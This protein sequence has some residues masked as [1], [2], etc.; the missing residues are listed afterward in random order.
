MGPPFALSG[1]R[2]GFTRDDCLEIVRGAEKKMGALTPIFPAPG[3]GMSLDR[4]PEML[5][6]YGR[7]VILLIGGGPMTPGTDLVENC[8][9]FRALVEV[10]R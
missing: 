2:F 10:A 9:R 5:G 7:E 1:E 3:G 8:R 6:T 4:V